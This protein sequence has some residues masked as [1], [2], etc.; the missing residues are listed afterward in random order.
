VNQL[1][2][3]NYRTAKCPVCN[4]KE[5]TRSGDLTYG[6]TTE[7]STHTVTLSH[8]PEIWKCNVCNSSFTQNA[9]PPEVAEKLYETGEG[10]K[11]WSAVNF[12]MDKTT[13]VRNI[14]DRFLVAKSN[15]LDIGCNTGEFLDYAKERSMETYGLEICEESCNIVNRKGHT[16]YRFSKDIRNKFDIVTA[17]DVVEHVY[18]TPGF[19]SFVNSLLNV[20]GHF[21]IL[22]GNPDSLSAR[23]A[24]Y[25]WWYYNYPEHVVFPSPVSFEQIKEF[26]VISNTKVYASIEHEK[27]MK[28]VKLKNSLIEL[29]RK[30]YSGRPALFP[31][32]QLV[33][34]KKL[35]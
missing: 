14:L 10:S 12:K 24:G 7:F 16:G 26:K 23:L 18:D 33:V 32:H 3:N 1:I 31:D 19:F 29:A 20:G 8:R 9:I 11:R 13:D 21:I 25:Q 28:L 30:V 15:V 22:T 2:E 17:F 27:G 35:S 4:S 6:G 34:L 5:I